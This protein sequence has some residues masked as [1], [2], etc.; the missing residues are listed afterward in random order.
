MIF[1]ESRRNDRLKMQSDDQQLL[2][3]VINR[4]VRQHGNRVL[5]QKKEENVS[6][7]SNVIEEEAECSFQQRRRAQYTA[8]RS[9]SLAWASVAF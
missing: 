9:G 1:V 4:L 2:T 7:T 5:G 6:Q 3:R 8:G